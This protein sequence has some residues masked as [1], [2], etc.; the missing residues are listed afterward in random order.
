MKRGFKIILPLLV[1]AL[2][3]SGCVNKFKQIK[4]TS[5]SL[6]SIVP[7]GLKSFD[8]LI[9]LGIDNPAP[10]FNIM[11]LKA[12]IMKDSIVVLRAAAENVAVDGKCSREYKIPVNGSID[13]GISRFKLAIMARNFNP[14]EYT[15]NLSARATIAGIGK[16]LE[17]KLPL[18]KLLKMK[19][20]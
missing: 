1:G 8:A 17:Y 4:I 16:D 19:E 5:A 6:E 15:V 14:E 9:C 18:G 2:C 11:H 13:P 12:D 3:L 10:S 7:T 20:E